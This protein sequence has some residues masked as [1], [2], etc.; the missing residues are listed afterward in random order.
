ME[1]LANA[2]SSSTAPGTMQFLKPLEH[3]KF[4]QSVI[5][6]ASVDAEW[7]WIIAIGNGVKAEDLHSV[8][9]NV[10]VVKWAPQLSILERA[11]IMITH[12]GANTVKECIWFG[13][14]MILFPMGLDQP[15]TA[16]RVAFHGFGLVG[17][18]RRISAGKIRSLVQRIA[19]GPRFRSRV[20]LMRERFRSVDSGIASRI[21][22]SLMD[23]EIP[24][25]S[26][27][28]V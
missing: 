24:A 18:I 12:G 21:I 28:G 6:A 5:D 7:Q 26:S 15:G 13:V 9:Q 19:T 1:R 25:A 2:R 20:E 17:D 3:R 4:Y 10:L 22:G 27:S 11:H 23:Q 16:A 8:P 14:P